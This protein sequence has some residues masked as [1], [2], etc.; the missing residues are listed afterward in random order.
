MQKSALG[1]NPDGTGTSDF[2]A[3]ES[4]EEN[5]QP[6]G[7]LLYWPHPSETR[8][9]VEN[10]HR[11]LV[12]KGTGNTTHKAVMGVGTGNPAGRAVD[13]PPRV[14]AQKEHGVSLYSHNEFVLQEL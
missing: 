6:L 5:T 1:P 2:Q 3:L 11:F 9:T 14:E 12:E 4:L 10:S 7:V 13:Q 8:G